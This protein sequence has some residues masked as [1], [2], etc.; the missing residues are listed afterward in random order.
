MLTHCPSHLGRSI[1]GLA[2]L[3]VLFVSLGAAAIQALPEDRDKPM[4]IT[5]DK[6]ER[7]DVNG[8]TIYTGNVILIQGTLKVEADKLTIYHQVDEDP[9]EIVAEGKPAKWQQKPERDKETVFARAR[10]I[11]YYKAE[12]RVN[13]QTDGYV[14]QDGS[15]VNGDSIDYFI[16]KQLVKAKSDQNRKGDRVVVVI[17][18]SAQKNKDDSGAT[19][20][21]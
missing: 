6:A 2:R 10:V 3:L 19:E 20:S 13:L 4:R 11:T 21:K 5:A 8:I 9:S 17:P 12:D 7:D 1:K 14:E 16:E 18:P 15:V